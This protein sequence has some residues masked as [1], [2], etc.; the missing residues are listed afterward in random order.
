MTHTSF[1]VA[2]TNATDSAFRAWG[3][4][5][6]AAL[7]QVGMVK[8][9]TAGQIDWATVL[10]PTN[11]RLTQGFEIWRFDDQLQA[12]HPLFVKIEYGSSG[13]A[14]VAPGLTITVG[15][16][17]TG[18]TITG[19][20]VPRTAVSD[21]TTSSTG[22]ASDTPQEHIVSTCSGRSCLVVV[23]NASNPSVYGSPVF[24]LER[25]RD[26]AG[27]ATGD[28]VSFTCSMGAVTTAIQSAPPNPFYATA[29]ASEAQAVGAIPAV[30]PYTLSGAT[31]T[32]SS[33]LATGVIAPVLPWVAFAPGLAPWQPLAALTYAPGDA[34]G[35]SII[36]TRLLGRDLPY[37]VIP[38]GN[39]HNGWGISLRENRGSA[40][41]GGT[42]ATNRAPG[43]MVLWED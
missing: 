16:G 39:G 1:T 3:S 29:Y 27:R 36:T 22:A 33:S 43:L 19:V 6:S 25:S 38:V 9:P 5:L 31:L 14:P 2:P 35:G 32:A 13:W 37:R 12:T 11:I 21:G 40:S 10:A 30:L 28:G 34:V 23:F 7:A 26:N 15:K 24:V 8:V 17:V 41:S 42:L 18:P 4:G 20:L